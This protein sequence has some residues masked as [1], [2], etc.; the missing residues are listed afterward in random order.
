MNSLLSDPALHFYGDGLLD[1]G[2]TERL[3]ADALH[4][5]DD[6]ELFLQYAVSESFSFDDGRLK[7]A[8][9]DSQKGFGL[10]GVAGEMTA[11]AHANELSDAAI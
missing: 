3:V 10:R 11:F 6:G 2:R 7:S 1:P 4:G 5:C 9:Y 8:S